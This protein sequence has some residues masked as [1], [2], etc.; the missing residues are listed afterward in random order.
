MWDGLIQVVLAHCVETMTLPVKQFPLEKVWERFPDAPR[1]RL[2]VP[3]YNVDI[4][5]GMDDAQLF[6]YV[7]KRRQKMV[8]YQ[9]VVGVYNNLLVAGSTGLMVYREK[10]DG[11]NMIEPLHVLDNLLPLHR[12]SC[13]PLQQPPTGPCPHARARE[14]TRQER[15]AAGI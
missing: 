15:A 4:L 2:S 1:S 11:R 12:G 10:L 5:V 3:I 8:L 14:A 9:S 7:I 6:P 13:C